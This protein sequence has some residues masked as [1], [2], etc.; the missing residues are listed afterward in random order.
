MYNYGGIVYRLWAEGVI[1]SLMGIICMFLFSHFG[2]KDFNKE[3]FHGG[4]FVFLVGLYSVVHC[5]MCL[6]SPNVSSFEGTFYQYNRDSR[7]AP[8]LPFT[9]RYI[10]YHGDTSEYVYLDT[11]TMEQIHPDDLIIG[12][13]YIIYYED[14]DDIIVGIEEVGE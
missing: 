11:F 6:C 13:N 12:E 14:H 1:I 3:I 2:K 10:F 5:I 8:P 9:N 7:E 4:I